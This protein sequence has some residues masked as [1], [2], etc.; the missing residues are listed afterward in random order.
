MSNLREV[1][2]WSLELKFS[3]ARTSS[4]FVLLSF[5]LP[6]APTFTVYQ[7]TRGQGSHCLFVSASVWTFVYVS[8]SNPA[9]SGFCPPAGSMSAVWL[10]SHATIYSTVST[11]SPRCPYNVGQSII[12]WPTYLRWLPTALAIHPLGLF[13]NPWP[14]PG[15]PPLVP[16]LPT[17]TNNGCLAMTITFMSVTVVTCSAP[18]P[19]QH[20]QTTTPQ[21]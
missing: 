17:F 5:K 2:P 10:W 7:V 13:S 16:A 14:A 4:G 21:A 18:L 11:D 3:T 6:F 12:M 8:T 19:L 9:L 1:A 15:N 20:S